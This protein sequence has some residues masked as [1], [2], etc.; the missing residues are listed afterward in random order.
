M[1]IDH[2]NRAANLDLALVIT[3][4]SCRN[5]E[6]RFIGRDVARDVLDGAGDGVLAVQRAL[7]PAQHFDAL[8]IVNIEQRTLRTRDINIIDVNANARFEAPQRIVL[9][10]A[11]DVCV[12]GAAGGAAAFTLMFGANAVMSSSVRTF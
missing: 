4:A 10:D 3:A 2:R 5:I 1:L 11:A 6:R 9:S 8:H 12:D 7:R